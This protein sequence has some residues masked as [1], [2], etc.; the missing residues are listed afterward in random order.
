[1]VR[2][3]SIARNNCPREPC[4]RYRT[5]DCT[6]WPYKDD[7]APKAHHLICRGIDSIWEV[8]LRSK[9]PTSGYVTMKISMLTAALAACALTAPVLAAQEIPTPA[10]PMMR[11]TGG[12]QAGPAVTGNPQADPRAMGGNQGYPGMTGGY[13]QG[14]PGSMGGYQQG[15]PGMMGGS[16]GWP[17]MGGSKGWWPNMMGGSSG[18]P[19][20]MGGRQW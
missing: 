16:Q 12:P 11:G 17:G 3:S 13:Q 8:S 14:Y 20:M 19:G 10:V 9:P 2:L 4:V 5:D 15:Y 7:V 6:D 1:M 18:W